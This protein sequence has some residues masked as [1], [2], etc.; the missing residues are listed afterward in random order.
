MG[1]NYA[2]QVRNA[3][4]IVELAGKAGQVPVMRA[5]RIRC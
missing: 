2:Q 5:W 1:P 3:L 4:Y